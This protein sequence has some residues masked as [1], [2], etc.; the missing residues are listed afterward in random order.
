VLQEVFTA[1]VNAMIADERP[2]NVR[3]WLYRIARKR[4]LNHLRRVQAIGVDP[5]DAQVS[6]HGASAADEVHRREEFR[7]LVHGTAGPAPQPR[8]AEQQRQTPATAPFRPNRR[9]LSVIRDARISR[10][11]VSERAL[12][13]RS[14]EEAAFAA[15]WRYRLHQRR[16]RHDV[17]G[18]S[19]P[20]V[21]QRFDVRR[22]DGRPR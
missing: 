20:E 10:A 6:E 8:P 22:L 11:N 3:P 5:M 18:L 14:Y 15:T 1:A 16:S 13:S 4:S 12:A 9:Q 17:G 19:E 2:L 21:P 7:R